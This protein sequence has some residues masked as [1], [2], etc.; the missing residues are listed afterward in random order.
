MI[1][2]NGLDAI[3]LTSDLD[4]FRGQLLTVLRCADA[5][6]FIET[7]VAHIF[8]M[9]VHLL[10]VTQLSTNS[11]DASTSATSPAFLQCPLIN[12]LFFLFFLESAEYFQTL[13]VKWLAVSLFLK[14]LYLLCL[15]LQRRGSACLLVLVGVQPWEASTR[16]GCD[17][18]TV[19]CHAP[20]VYDKYKLFVNLLNQDSNVEAF[21]PRRFQ[22]Y[23]IVLV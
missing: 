12:F 16:G 10:I 9:E 19:D 1:A 11:L 15:L 4:Q 8:S 14:C 13:A 7:V 17:Y 5:F 3:F 23:N 18:V 6:L 20:K 21:M 22:F 2:D